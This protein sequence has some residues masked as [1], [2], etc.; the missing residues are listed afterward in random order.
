[1]AANLGD[2]ADTTAAVFGQLAGAYYG[3]QGIP[4]EWVEKLAMRELIE[5]TAVRLLAASAVA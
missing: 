1:A 3:V 5:E 4:R 2:D